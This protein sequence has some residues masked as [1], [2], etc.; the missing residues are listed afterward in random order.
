MSYYNILTKIKAE[1]DADP[2][3]NT[4]TEGDLNSVDL[5]KQTIFP[6]T[7]IIINN[8]TFRGN[9]I[10]YNISILAMDIVDISKE[11]TTNKFR[12]NDNEHDIFNTQI[13]LL[14]RLYEKLR[15]GNLYDDNYQVD[16][17]PN[18]EPFTDRFENKLCG[19]TMT[20]NMVVPNEMTVCDV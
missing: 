16:G 12:G 9:I 2:F 6:L 7:H 1:L 4:T 15:R 18:C 10:Q 5:N 8:A 13:S 19:W 14:N 3:T 20:F 17:N 11:E